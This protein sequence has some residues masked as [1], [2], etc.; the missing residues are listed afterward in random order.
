MALI[1]LW[2]FPHFQIIW[3]QNYPIKNHIR[4][5][6]SST[7]TNPFWFSNIMFENFNLATKGIIIC[8]YVFSVAYQTNWELR[9]GINGK[10]FFFMG[11]ASTGCLS[12]QWGNKNIQLIHRLCGCGQR[13]PA[14]ILCRI[15]HVQ[16]S[17]LP[18][19]CQRPRPQDNK[20][21]ILKA[22]SLS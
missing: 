8:S 16:N 9:L 21:V 7:I 2:C 12:V 10:L 22:I 6:I 20:N 14:H 11:G 3:Y 18:K 5:L 1:N 17:K 15:E 19:N 13:G 4:T